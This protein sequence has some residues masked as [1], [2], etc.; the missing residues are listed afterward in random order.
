[1]HVVLQ[2]A[3]ICSRTGCDTA[4]KKCAIYSGVGMVRRKC[5]LVDFVIIVVLN[6]LSKSSTLHALCKQLSTLFTVTIFWHFVVA[7]A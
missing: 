6:D 2:A 1:M 5:V 3:F 4:R 7:H